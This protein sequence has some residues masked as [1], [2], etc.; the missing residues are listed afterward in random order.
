M[1]FPPRSIPLPDS[2]RDGK[3]RIGISWQGS[4]TYSTDQFRSTMLETF[5]PLLQNPWM[6]LYSLHVGEAAQQLHDSEGSK[7]IVDTSPMQSDLADAAAII[8][9]LDV[10]LSVDTAMLH[11]AASMGVPTWGLLSQLGDW[12]WLDQNRLDSP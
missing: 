3:I 11:L 8:Q 10:V 2:K 1:T 6:E 5:A 4:P 7:Q 12:R 9:Q